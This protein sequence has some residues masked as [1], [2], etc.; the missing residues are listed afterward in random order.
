MVN[1][2]VVIM[3]GGKGTRLYPYTQIVPKPLIPIGDKS[4]IEHIFERF[5]EFG[6]KE[7]ILTLNYKKSMIK[8][9][10][11]DLEG[12]YNFTYIEE[13]DYYG[14]AGSLSLL[15]G[16]IDKTFFVT[17]CDILVEADYQK[18]IETHTSSGNK[19][20][21]VTSFQNFTIPYGVI[22][23]SDAG[24]VADIVEKP[25]YEVQINTGV[26]VLEPEVLNDIPA[27]KLF[28]I[29]DLINIYLERGEQIGVFSVGS[30]EWLDMG[31]ISLLHE[32][33]HKI[34]SVDKE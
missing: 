15:K 22:N 5:H 25:K 9:Y 4:I 34:E 29:T 14:T 27:G 12:E 3:A 11:D 16:Q 6:C 18:I 24:N 8:S 23:L 26:Y 10:L 2:K 30:E 31:E 1:N 28:H 33:K 21:M 7:F 19:I 13:A 17:N 20:T 32:M